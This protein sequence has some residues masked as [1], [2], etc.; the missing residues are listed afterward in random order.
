MLALAGNPQAGVRGALIAGTNGKGSTAALLASILSAG[1]GRIGTMP[2]PHLSS[3]T[4]RV[5]VNGRPI[6]EA[7]FAAAVD[8]LRGRLDELPAE[9]GPPTEFEILTVVA[10]SYLARQCDLLV[11]EVGMGGRLDATNVLDLGIA[12]ITNVT[13]DHA[14][15][16]G[17]TVE[18][19]AAEKAG[20]IKPGNH[21]LTAAEGGALQVVEERAAAAPAQLWRLGHELSLRARSRGWQGSDIDVSG[22]G[23]SHE[24]LH[25]PLVGEHQAA[26]A[27]LAVAAGHLLGQSPEAIGATRWPGRLELVGRSPMVVL[28]GGH[29]PDALRRLGREIRHLEEPRRPIVVFGLMADKDVEGCLAGLRAMD[30]AAVVFTS[31]SGSRPARP[32]LLATAWG[33]GEVADSPEEAL[34]RAIEL[35]GP[36]GLVVVCGSLYLVG[37][38]RPILVDRPR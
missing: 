13:I 23:F 20:I 26:N 4:E 14:Q 8:E 33:G 12:V 35:A 37:E 29:N 10:L 31:A 16:L 15:Y 2:S 5:Q 22:P 28:D 38:L 19:I 1:G 34:G 32:E 36:Q 27:A 9:L 11:I 18:K 25:V 7:D 24:N 17:D 3:Y 30:P 6:S 21:V